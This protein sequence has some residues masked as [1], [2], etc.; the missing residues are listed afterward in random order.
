MTN[1]TDQF[2]W[3]VVITYMNFR[4]MTKMTLMMMLMMVDNGAGYDRVMT[5]VVV[6]KTMKTTT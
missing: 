3:Y 1:V 6:T 2:L 4:H 5:I